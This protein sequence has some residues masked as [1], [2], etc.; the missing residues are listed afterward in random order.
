[1]EI[2]LILGISVLAISFADFLVNNGLIG[3]SGTADMQRISNAVKK[4]DRAFL[5]R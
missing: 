3:S 4:R 1:M 5:T 2:G